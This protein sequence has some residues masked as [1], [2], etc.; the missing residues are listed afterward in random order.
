[1]LAASGDASVHVFT[2]TE[3]G[4]LDASCT[5]RYDSQEAEVS[6]LRDGR[7]LDY[8]LGGFGRG[9]GAGMSASR[10]D[11]PNAEVTNDLIVTRMEFFPPGSGIIRAR[12]RHSWAV[13]YRI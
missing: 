5:H 7:R 2:V 12:S 1:M 8:F 3:A 9:I 13:R 11:R 6:L 4:H 10:G